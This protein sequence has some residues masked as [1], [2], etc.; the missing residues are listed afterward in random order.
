MPRPSAGHE[1]RGQVVARPMRRARPDV[2]RSVIRATAIVPQSII[3][4][5]C[6]CARIIAPV[7]VQAPLDVT[8]AI[9]ALV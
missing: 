8:T 1:L 9:V 5:V 2:R 7:A 6:V 3:A 4:Q